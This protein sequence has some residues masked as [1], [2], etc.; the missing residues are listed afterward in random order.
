MCTYG[1]VWREL[2]RNRNYFIGKVELFQK[3]GTVGITSSG[4]LHLLRVAYI[5][6]YGIAGVT[7]TPN[8]RVLYNTTFIS[9]K[10]YQAVT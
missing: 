8:T 1:A 6:K 4:F 10:P 5:F 7:E 9:A 2:T 3:P